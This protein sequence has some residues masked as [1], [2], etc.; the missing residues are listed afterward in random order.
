MS[1]IMARPEHSPNTQVTISKDGKT[2]IDANGYPQG[3]VKI[4]AYDQPNHYEMLPESL[5]VRSGHGASHTFLLHEVGSGL[6]EDRMPPVNGREALAS[7]PP[8]ILPPR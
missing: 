4:V 1:Y 2:V 6:A 3:A 5:R 8:G 7:T